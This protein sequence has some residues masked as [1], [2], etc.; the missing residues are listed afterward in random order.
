[1]NKNRPHYILAFIFSLTLLTLTCNFL[2]SAAPTSVVS[3]QVP[4]LMETPTQIISASPTNS[5]I[6]ENTSA[7][8]LEI[9]STQTTEDPIMTDVQYYYE[10]GYLPYSTGALT[11]LPDFLKA[12]PSGSVVNDFTRTRTEAQDF[13]LWADIELN[14]IGSTVYPKYTGC[15][16]AYRVQ[17]GSAGYTAILTNDYVRMGA[18]SS[19]MYQCELFGTV[20]GDGKVNV[21]NKTKAQFSLAVNKN[22]AYA[23][24]DGTLVG[25]YDLYTTRLQG[26]GDLYYAAVSN[27]SAGYWSTCQMTNIRLWESHP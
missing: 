23:F 10:K 6:V 4:S 19:G 3:S 20:A 5:P 24:V 18:C 2:V 27:Y 15:G 7:P 13:A 14:T 12:Q 22:R 1:M 11:S 16:F 8:T 21:G 25:Q 9:Q 26:T 17:N